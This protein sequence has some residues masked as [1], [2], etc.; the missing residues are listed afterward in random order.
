MPT[1][2]YEKWQKVGEPNVRYTP[3]A[4]AHGQGGLVDV[5]LLAIR[6]HRL[7]P[8]LILVLPI[9]ADRT[10]EVWCSFVKSYRRWTYHFLR[11]IEPYAL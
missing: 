2:V 1:Q 9:D 3:D 6:R 8:L 10:Y 5:A 11:A 7:P 4:L